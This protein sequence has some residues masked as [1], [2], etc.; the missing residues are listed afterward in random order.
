MFQGGASDTT[1]ETTIGRVTADVVR[2]AA[3]HVAAI[4]QALD[5]DDV[6]YSESV[7]VWQEFSRLARLGNA[8]ATL[9]ARRVDESRRWAKAGHGTVD[10]FI[11][12]ESGETLGD[13]RK[14]RKTSE[15]LRDLPDT[16]EQLRQG[17]LSR[18]QSDVISDAATANP[19][20]EQQLLDDAEKKSVKDLKDQ[21]NR[22][23]AAADRDPEATAKRVH[24]NRK[25]SDWSKGDGSHCV[26]GNGPVDDMAVLN[27]ALQ[28]IVDRYYKTRRN[29]PEQA[30]RHAYRWDALIDIA[31]RSLQ[32]PTGDTPPAGHEPDEPAKPA[33]GPTTPPYLGILRMDH[34]ALVRGY[35]E[36]DELCEI[37]GLGPIPVARA[38]ELLGEST[39]RLVLTR[40]IDVQ[41]VTYLGRG[42]NAAQKIA[43]LWSQ[44]SCTNIACGNTW[45]QND[46]REPYAKVKNTVLSNIDPLCPH[47]HDL[48]TRFG[49]ALING[50]GERPFVPPDHPQH[51]HNTPSGAR[52]GPAPPNQP[53]EL[54]PDTG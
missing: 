42:V 17:R 48:K 43:L 39:L 1:E 19:S 53:P 47:D 23:K 37:A 7:E 15:R 4:L 5:P 45:V 24:R 21:A 28:P 20:A 35:V 32:Q 14:Q 2:S 12:A 49:W 26:Y 36:G 29:T 16:E 10:D 8:G 38:R 54:F 34:S 52:D 41:N 40:G 27:A 51:P 31:R 50:K 9:V 6:L 30:E 3:D 25:L 22:A 11:A 46:H 33:K 44:P 13:A 18:E